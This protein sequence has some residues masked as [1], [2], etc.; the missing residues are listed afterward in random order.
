MKGGWLEHEIRSLPH[1]LACS[2]TKDDVVVLIEASADPIAVE[3]SVQAAL[4]RAGNTSPVRVFGG[5]RPAFVEPV[6]VRSR[7]SALVGTVGGAAILAAGIWLAGASTGLRSPRSKAPATALAPP[8]AREVV[9]VPA[10]GGAAPEQLLPPA[11]TPLVPLLRKRKMFSAAGPIVPVVPGRS[12]H[13]GPPAEDACNAPHEGQAIRPFPGEGN[14]PPAW[15][16]SIHNPPNC[17]TG[18][19]S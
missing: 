5:D 7:P 16:H 6:R 18:R 3:R 13:G 8:P 2:L 10:V 19:N 9:R 17:A 11:E 15:S 12:R 4:D 14:G 1:V